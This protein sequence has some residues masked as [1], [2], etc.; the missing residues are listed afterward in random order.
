[1]HQ[2]L[3]GPVKQ[4][5]FLAKDIDSAMRCWVE[6]LGV[7]PWWGYRN[8]SMQTDFRGA[9]SEV[10]MHV[11]LAYQ[12]GVQIELIQQVN[13]AASP[14][15]FF[16]DRPE[17]QV[18]HQIG[19]LVDDIDAAIERGKRAGLAEH[20]ILRNAYNRYA[21]LESPLLTGMVIEL[22]PADPH[23]VAEYERCALEAAQ[24]DGSDPY[25]LAAL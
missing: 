20:G 2:Q 25:R 14:Y 11:A 6:Q 24:W 10:V 19:Y 23:F 12:N 21:Y 16:Q 22:M 17:P 18:L 15:R 13:D 4:W 8:V 7:G 9:T 3:F 5:G 1:M